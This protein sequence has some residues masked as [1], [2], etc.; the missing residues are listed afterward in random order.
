MITCSICGNTSARITSLYIEGAMKDIC[1]SCM[2]ISEAKGTKTSGILTRGAF[3]IRTQAVAG[4]GDT[5]P[6]HMY[7]KASKKVVPNPDFANRFNANADQ[8]FS[9]KEAV[10]NGMPKLAD[11]IR[12]IKRA[13]VKKKI[14]SAIQYEGTTKQAMAKQLGL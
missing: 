3:R 6:S 12:K 7:D 10:A 14:D 13:K 8:Y 1:A 4:E 9:E 5:I 2:G 11:H